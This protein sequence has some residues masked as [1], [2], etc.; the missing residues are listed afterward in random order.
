MFAICYMALTFATIVMLALFPAGKRK[1]VLVFSALFFGL[2]GFMMVP[3]PTVYVDT[4]RFFNTLDETRSFAVT[5]TGEAWHYLMDVC[6]YNATPVIGVIIY[7]LSL[8]PE[9]GWLTFLAAA[10]DV[11]AG[12]YLCFKQSDNGGNRRT[13]TLS[14]FFFLALLNFNGSVSGIRTCMAG[15]TAICLI[16][17]YSNKFNVVFSLWFLP[18][19]LIH[20]FTAVVLLF[21]VLSG[22]YKKYNIF[23]SVCCLTCLFQHYI[24]AAVLSTVSKLSFIPFFASI[25]F[26]S[27]QY[28]GEGAYITTGYYS[29]LRFM[30]LFF[31]CVLILVYALWKCNNFS[32]H[33][34][35]FVIL[36]IC[37]SAGSIMDQI[38]FS[39]CVAL[40]VIAVLPFMC[41]IIKHSMSRFYSLSSFLFFCALLIFIDNLRAGIRFQDIYVSWNS[42][43][44]FAVIL[45]SYVIF[46]FLNKRKG[47]I[48]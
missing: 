38:L 6:G 2:I 21:F 44:L 41:E 46:L 18:L 4:V 10:V 11:G 28:F 22:A 27:T 32:T 43:L 17:H 36:L 39:R 37:F 20:P 40:L 26:K 23:Y 42:L 29:N 3:K 9:N 45:I 24:Q 12:F 19:I 30:L 8:Q 47:S 34:V 13:L 31:F 35:G 14:I 16:Y 15:F 25:S 1:T 7:L 33:Y 48:K 5:D